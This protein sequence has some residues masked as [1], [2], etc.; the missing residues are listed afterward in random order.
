MVEAPGAPPSDDPEIVRRTQLVDVVRS[1]PAGVLVPI[2]STIVLTIA[3][4][5]FDAAGWVKGL[6]AAAAGI[7]LLASPF[8]T[9]AARRTRRPVMVIAAAVSL[10]GAAGFVLAASGAL[11]LM[12]VGSMIGVAAVSAPIPLLTATYE[13]N[14]AARDR[15][16]RVGRGMA[17]RVAVSALAGLAM[18]SYLT[19][20]PDRWWQLLVVA[21]AGMAAVAVCQA[22]LPSEPLAPLEGHTSV[23]PHFHLVA[24]DRQ[25]RLTLI[26]WMFMGFGNLMLLPLRVEYLARPVYGVGADA[27]KIT[28]LTVTV[29]SIVRLV[30]MPVFGSLFDRLSFFS[31]RIMVNLLFALYVAAF[32]S[33]SSDVGLVLGAVA[34][35]VASAGGDLMWSLWVTKFAPPGRVADYMGL[36]TFFTGVRAV[37]APILGFL[38]IERFDLGTVAWIATAMMIV[39]SMVLLPEARLER[40]AAAERVGSR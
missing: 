35:G 1:I 21:A 28:M 40:R 5:R 24:E 26:A 34:F 11:S 33:G 4:T 22:N 13:R 32:F 36:H 25:L 31:A 23:L 18:G 19:T 9:A 29:P 15:G 38:V 6:I 39:S 20:H 27:A 7:G 10:V 12:V 8:L 2:E 37:T 30:C 14:F 16:R 3:I 17:V